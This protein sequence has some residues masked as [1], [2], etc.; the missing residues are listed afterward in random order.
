MKIVEG[1]LAH[2]Q[3]YYALGEG[4]PLVVLRWFS[5]DHANPHGWERKQE[6]KVMAPLAERYR[7]HAVNR[8]PGT[9]EGAT[10]A[11]L[12]TQLAEAIKAEFGGPVNVMG[13]SSGGSL[14]LQ[15]AAD[16]PETVKRLVVAGAAATLTGQ[17]RQAQRLYTEAVASGRRGAHHLVPIVG[18]TA[19]TRALLTPLMWLMDP[20]MR[21]K[22][23]ATDMLHFAQ[24][25]DTFDVRDRLG[26]FAM[27]VLVI[28]GERDLAYNRELF[29]QTADG[30]PDGR[31]I[32]YPGLGHMGTFT[33]KRFAPDI[34]SFLA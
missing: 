33:S 11:E 19:F 6:L 25:E 10:M 18:R 26:S 13:M 28:G 15:L 7:V 31:L 3:P 24:A 21:P 16:H 23:A 4:E 17:T 27:P 9:P 1:T 5:P 29:S 8:A 14:A 12:A 34:L 2:G 22:G 30:V 20:M 32:L